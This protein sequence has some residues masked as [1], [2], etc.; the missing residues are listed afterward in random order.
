MTIKKIMREENSTI[1]EKDLTTIKGKIITESIIRKTLTIKTK[2]KITTKM[3]EEASTTIKIREKITITI[4]ITQI[5]KITI[6]PKGSHRGAVT[7]IVKIKDKIIFLHTTIIVIQI[8]PQ[9]KEK[10]QDHPTTTHIITVPVTRTIITTTIKMKI[11]PTLDSKKIKVEVMQSEKINNK[12]KLI[13][14][15]EI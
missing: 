5:I 13:T 4:K 3:I 2:V 15:S 12:N 9:L 8:P 14:D 7:K 6:M 11:T 10:I 1:K